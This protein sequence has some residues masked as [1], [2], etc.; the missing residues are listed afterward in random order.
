MVLK[1]EN[2]QI[3]FVRAQWYDGESKRIPISQG[4]I[5]VTGHLQTALR[6]G[7]QICVSV[8]GLVNCE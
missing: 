6:A 8:C 2:T 1:V 3:D 7:N 4:V 5:K